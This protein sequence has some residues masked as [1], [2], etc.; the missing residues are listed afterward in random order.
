M[1]V[2]FQL[3]GVQLAFDKAMGRMA[4]AGG[5]LEAPDELSNALHHAYR[6]GELY[7][8]RRGWSQTQLSADPD[9]V[10]GVLGALFIRSFDTHQLVAVATAELGYPKVY[11]VFYGAPVWRCWRTLPDAKEHR[12]GRHLDYEEHLEGRDVVVTLR[13]ALDEL[14]ARVAVL[15]A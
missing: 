7:K 5:A 14:A 6:L 2:D 9:P 11:P 4:G 8:R 13:A 15:P 12:G 1:A 3:G 10:P